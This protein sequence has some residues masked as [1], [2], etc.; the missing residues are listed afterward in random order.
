MVV[1]NSRDWPEWNGAQNFGMSKTHLGIDF[2]QKI[3]QNLKNLPKSIGKTIITP[4]L[5]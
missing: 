4:H 1:L 5:C 3:D 2:M